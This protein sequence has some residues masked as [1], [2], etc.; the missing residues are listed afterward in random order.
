MSVTVPPRQ[1]ETRLE[2]A[3]PG[4]FEPLSWGRVVCWTV[5][6]AAF[7]YIEASVVLY[8]RRYAGMPIGLDYPAIL[9]ARGLPFDSP[10]ILALM[11]Q[12]DVL[13]AELAREAA[14]LLLLLGAAWGAG[15]TL[16]EKWGL[17]AFTFAVWDITYYLWLA[18][19]TGFPHS[20]T[21][22]D[23]YYLIPVA[24]YG[25][26]WFPLCVFMPVTLALALRLLRTPDRLKPAPLR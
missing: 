8:L 4:T 24:W 3:S 15:R 23:I 6:A 5:F 20:L 21:A 12:V 1:L 22:T 19:L 2:F 9:A 11:R 18:L 7:G 10:H 17:F 26:V 14:T 25:P 16:R 13:N